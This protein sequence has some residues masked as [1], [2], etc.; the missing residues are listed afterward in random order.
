MES[1]T[2]IFS[3]YISYLSSDWPDLLLFIF[4][5][6]VWLASACFSASI[7]ETRMRSLPLHF[8]GGL[9]LPIIYPVFILLKLP[10]YDSTKRSLQDRKEFEIIS[11]APPPVETAPPA[12]DDAP[13]AL[14]DSDML[15][16]PKVIFDQVYFKQ[17][18]VDMTGNYR[19]PFLLTVNN[20]K[21]KAEKII[22]SLLEVVLVEFLSADGK[23]QNMRIPYKNIESCTELS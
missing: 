20:E 14:V 19:G 12:M 7:A 17:I 15:N 18:A 22:D 2:T 10:V 8:F 6:A 23:V 11:G 3:E 9:L 16:K 13:P 1:L 5:I 4:I 21:L